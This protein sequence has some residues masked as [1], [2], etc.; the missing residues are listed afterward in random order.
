MTKRAMITGAGAGI[1]LATALALSRSDCR[2]FVVDVNAEAVAATIEAVRSEGHECDGI[3][4]SVADQEQVAAA[5]SAMDASFGG[6]DIL[7]N[8]AGITGNCPAEALDLETWNRVVGVNQTGTFLCAQAA[9]ARMR[10]E[11]SGCIVNLSSIYGLVAAP[12]R[13]AYSATK[14][15]V[16]MMTKALAVEW[17]SEGIRVNCIA[18]GY[19]E[20]PGTEELAQKGTINLE[21]LRQRT[22]QRRLAQ[23]DDIANAIVTIC[24][25]RLSH[26]TGQILAVDGGWSAYGYL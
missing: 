21:A 9:G 11:K 25:D 10:K 23:P 24:D 3:A 2:V 17:A 8:N 16:V 4:A 13:L 14:A 15:A 12:N 22:P 18:P 6:I 26:V 1:G 5:F 20:T 19:V 7:V